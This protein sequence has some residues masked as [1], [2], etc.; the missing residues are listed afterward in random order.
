MI[1]EGIDDADIVTARSNRNGRAT[2][3]AMMIF[4]TSYEDH[5]D[6]GGGKGGAVFMAAEG[7]WKK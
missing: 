7:G 5:E 3:H 4:M 1:P 6:R 2:P